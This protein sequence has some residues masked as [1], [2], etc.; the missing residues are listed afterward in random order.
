MEYNPAIKILLNNNTTHPFVA[1]ES[2]PD[3]DLVVQASVPVD[4]D[5]HVNDELENAE[6]VRIVGAR[7]GAIKKFEHPPHTKHTIDAHEREV[8][9]KVQVEQVGGQ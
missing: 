3:A 2:Y 7:I 6:N 5:D 4:A 8:N 9:A 1:A